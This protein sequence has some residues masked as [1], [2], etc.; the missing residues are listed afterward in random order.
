[1]T[2]LKCV[3]LTFDK[4]HTQ[5]DRYKTNLKPVFPIA[6]VGHGHYEKLSK[7]HVLSMIL[8]NNL[9]PKLADIIQSMKDFTT[10]PVLFDATHLFYMARVGQSASTR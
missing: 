9:N 5:T 4:L 1:M 8:N 10:W 6:Y 2:Y 7:N 3:F